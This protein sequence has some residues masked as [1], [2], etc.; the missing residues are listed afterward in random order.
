MI[1]IQKMMATT[2]S[3]RVSD[4]TITTDM[5]KQTAPASMI[6]W[7]GSTAVTPGRTMTS[8]PTRPSMIAAILR[9]LMRSPRKST[10]SSAPQIGVVNS[11]EI[12]CASG[13]MVSACSQANCP[14]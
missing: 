14:A 10:A 13:I 4:F 7:P 12:S 5:P 6:R 11:I 3:V 8:T 2:L 9:A 1:S